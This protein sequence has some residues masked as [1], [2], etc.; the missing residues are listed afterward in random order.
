MGV[1]DKDAEANVKALF[2]IPE[3]EPIFVLRAQDRLFCP[4]LAVYEQLYISTVRATKA[5]VQ[6]ASVQAFLNDEEMEFADHVGRDYEEGRKWQ[7]RNLN[8]VKIPD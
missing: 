7:L 2:G 6:S 3:D 5:E 1:H 4:M 8:R